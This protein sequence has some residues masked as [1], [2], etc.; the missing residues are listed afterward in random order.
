MS[1]FLGRENLLLRQMG[2]PPTLLLV[3]GRVGAGLADH[4][5][6]LSK[7]LWAFFISSLSRRARFDWA[8]AS[9]LL[10]FNLAFPALFQS[11]A[12]PISR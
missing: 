12:F 5:R 6:L 2:V 1:L 10:L 3:T 9:P 4:A 11:A 7:P 8:E